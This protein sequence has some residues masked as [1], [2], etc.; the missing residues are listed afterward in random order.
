MSQ[1]LTIARPYARAVFSD[2]LDNRLLTQWS[3]ILTALAY[4]VENKK[5]EQLIIDPT[6]TDKERKELFYSLVQSALPKTV[7][8]LGDRIER[9][10]DLLVDEKRL[11]LLPDIAFLY[12]QLL[13]E[14][15]GIIDA[16]VISAY[17]MS[18]DH[19]EGIKKALESRFNSKVSLN[20]SKDESLIGGA[21]IR[22]GNWVMD[23]SVKGKLA[24]LAE[25]LNSL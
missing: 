7:S 11:T 14:Q 4:I 20:F 5:A 21:I 15:Q 6:L 24:K 8:A 3:E 18:E 17:P 16:E 19:R 23:G 13:N 9:F 25:D 2:A 1:L 22:A 12:H 10:I